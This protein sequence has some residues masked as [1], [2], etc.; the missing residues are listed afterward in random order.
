VSVVT[1]KDRQDVVRKRRTFAMVGDP[2]H[3][4]KRA[5]GGVKSAAPGGSKPPPAAKAAVH[6]ASKSSARARAVSFG[7]GKPTSAEP[8]RERRPLSPV[9]TDEAAAG[10]ADLDM[11]ICMEDYCVGGVMMFDAHTGR[12]LVGEFF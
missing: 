1:D 6:G 11:E 12:G 7:P 10:G 9:H 2:S 5:W 4:V 3:E 8:T